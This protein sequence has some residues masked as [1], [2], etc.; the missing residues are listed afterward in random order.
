MAS[1]G[2]TVTSSS[3]TQQLAYHKLPYSILRLAGIRCDVGRPVD[4][5]ESSEQTDC[6]YAEQ[7]GE[8]V[9]EC[10]TY[11]RVYCRG[12]RRYV[13]DC[14]Y[15]GSI[16][17]CYVCLNF[18]RSPE[19]LSEC[20]TPASVTDIGANVQHEQPVVVV[21]GTCRP[22]LPTEKKQLPVYLKSLGYGKDV[23]H[24]LAEEKYA[25]TIFSMMLKDLGKVAPVGVSKQ[26]HDRFRINGP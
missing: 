11:H 18:I 23:E 16:G 20:K 13:C 10:K 15:T 5:K 22:K 24:D 14:D 3:S 26:S 8:H 19:L 6:N 7:N 25:E 9:L 17:F 21:C 4:L 12:Y 1:A 2:G